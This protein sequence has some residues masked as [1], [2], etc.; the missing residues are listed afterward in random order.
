LD[1]EISLEQARQVQYVVRA[2]AAEFGYTTLRPSV[3]A[4]LDCKSSP[5]LVEETRKFI[6][7]ANGPTKARTLIAY[8]LQEDE[9]NRRL[10]YQRREELTCL[11]ETL[12]GTGLTKEERLYLNRRK[13]ELERVCKSLEATL[14]KTS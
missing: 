7:K 13:R 11:E 10:I 2:L 4:L 3:D 8:V 9:A 5:I 6:N 1:K 12:A 14:L